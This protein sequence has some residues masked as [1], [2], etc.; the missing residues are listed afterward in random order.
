[1]ILASGRPWATASKCD[2]PT[3][4]KLVITLKSVLALPQQFHHTEGLG[5][6]DPDEL[7]T[8]IHP[9][10]VVSITPVN[11]EYMP[12][13]PGTMGTMAALR[14]SQG[15]VLLWRQASTLPLLWDFQWVASSNTHRGGTVHQPVLAASTQDMS[16]PRQQRIFSAQLQGW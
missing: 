9:L 6:V 8:G 2:V 13:H 7:A 4:V 10:T 15:N 3:T 12:M 1:M 11:F 5:C 16:I 14:G